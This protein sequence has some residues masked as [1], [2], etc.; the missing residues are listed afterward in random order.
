MLEMAEQLPKYGWTPVVVGPRGDVVSHAEM[1]GIETIVSGIRHHGSVRLR[2]LPGRRYAL[3]RVLMKMLD[4][5]LNILVLQRLVR[6]RDL[7]VLHSN[8]L[9]GHLAV[10]FAAR[11]GGVPAV[12]H[13]RDI[14]RA[15]PG[16]RVLETV[17]KRVA[18]VIAISHACATS[19]PG[20]GAKVIYNPVGA[21]IVDPHPPLPRADD[22]P[23][24]GYLGRLDPGKG[25]EDL[26]GAAAHLPDIRVALVGRSFAGGYEYVQSLRSLAEVSAPGRVTFVGS[27][28]EP[29]QALMGMDVLVVPSIEE[30]FGRVA[31]E[32][33]LVG[34]PV[35]VA[36][37]GGLPEI[38]T[39]GV[40]GLTFPPGDFGTLAVALGRVLTDGAL[41]TKLIDAALVSVARFDPSRHS[42]SVAT[43]LDEIMG[44]SPEGGNEERTCEA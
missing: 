13:V 19:L 34:T 23:V 10:A 22:R 28:E 32:A 3:G 27:V 16:R 8:S 26:L 1:R 33:Q 15:G 41:R 4:L 17:G 29:W 11:I 42:C 39:D 40:D 20:V 44:L 31:V 30:P 37:S 2:G 9:P 35:V 21:P 12:W 43:F 7:D 6:H 38:V 24:V 25:I 36:R 18:G 5:G 14:V